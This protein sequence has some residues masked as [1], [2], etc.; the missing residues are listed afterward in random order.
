MTYLNPYK[1]FGLAGV[2]RPGANL[3][4]I[5]YVDTSARGGDDASS[6]LSVENPKLSIEG[7]LADCTDAGFDTI[8]VLNQ[9]NANCPTFPIAVDKD[10]VTIIAAPSGSYQPRW[11]GGAVIDSG[12]QHCFTMHALHTRI[13][14]FD[15]RA[16][17]TSAGVYFGDADCVRPGI[18]RC[19]FTAGQYGVHASANSMPGTGLEIADCLFA[20]QTTNAILY[21]SNGPFFRFHDNHF[22]ESV[23]PAINF[24]GIGGDGGRVMNNT[25]QLPDDVQ[26]RAI[27]MGFAA[28]GPVW[29]SGNQANFGDVALVA[30][31]YEYLSAA[32]A[33]GV[34][35]AG[36]IAVLPA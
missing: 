28:L 6:G 31:P 16:G 10:N 34:N 5:L 35:Y 3:G 36:I 33:W 17:T 23:G 7:A 8:V 29:V 9:D 32:A 13:I 26:G 24:T 25:F 27:T 30:N 20:S 12:E 22:H 14:G 18:F 21:N 1:D 11:E 15:L 2:L 19:V 4:Q